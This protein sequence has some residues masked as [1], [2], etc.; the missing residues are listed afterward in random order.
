[1]KV[2][3]IAAAIDDRVPAGVYTG[4]AHHYGFFGSERGV[5]AG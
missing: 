5:R 1:L 2:D 4:V 3:V